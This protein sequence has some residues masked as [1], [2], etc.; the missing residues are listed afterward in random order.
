MNI[1]ENILAVKY[2][3]FGMRYVRTSLTNSPSLKENAV[4]S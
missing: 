1:S 3:K 2:L 4:Q